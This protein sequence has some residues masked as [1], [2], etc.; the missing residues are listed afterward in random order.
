[1][2]ISVLSSAFLSE[3]DAKIADNFIKKYYKNIIEKWI[4]FFVLKKAIRSTRITKRYSMA[5]I[6]ILSAKYIAPL[7]IE[8]YFSDNTKRLVNI[9]EYIKNILIF[10]TIHI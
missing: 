6:S 9:G 7:S 1:M 2:N 5:L 10:N 3:K 8:I 4:K